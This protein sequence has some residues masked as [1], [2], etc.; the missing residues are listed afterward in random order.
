MLAVLRIAFVPAL[1]LCNAMPRHE[2]PTLIHADYAFVVLMA[3]FSFS[4][5]YCANIAMIWAPKSVHSREREMASS[6]MAAF[7]GVGLA[8]GSSISLIMVQ[9]L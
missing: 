6:M 5:G 8:C 2:I 7:L 4:N 1:L 3:A 9:L